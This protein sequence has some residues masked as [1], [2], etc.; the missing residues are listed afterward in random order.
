MP[1]QPEALIMRTFRQN[2]GDL[3]ISDKPALANVEDPVA[4]T[5]ALLE[6]Y[7]PDEQTLGRKMPL[8]AQLISEDGRVLADF[9]LGPNG[10]EQ[11]ACG[12]DA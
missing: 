10:A 4:A 3:G 5:K 7:F 11:T 1:P 2:P 9:R 12:K 6:S 8:R